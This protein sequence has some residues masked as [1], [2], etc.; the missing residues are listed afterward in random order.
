MFFYLFHNF[1]L[2]EVELMSCFYLGEAELEKN[3]EESI[4]VYG[5]FTSIK[6]SNEDLKHAHSYLTAALNSAKKCKDKYVS[7]LK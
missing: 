5:N 4:E 3:I 7:L 1:H 2:E 6:L